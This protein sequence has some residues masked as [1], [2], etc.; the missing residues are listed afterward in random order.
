MKV[1]VSMVV[2]GA[3][4]AASKRYLVFARFA[5]PP[6]YLVDI[7]SGRRVLQERVRGDAV[8][9]RVDLVHS[10]WRQME[11]KRPDGRGPRCFSVAVDD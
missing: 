5:L 2:Q 6:Q 4:L 9:V 7:S 11:T 3:M 1:G 10:L 8:A